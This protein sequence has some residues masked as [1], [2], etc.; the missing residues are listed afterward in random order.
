MLASY[1]AVKHMLP[2][3]KYGIVSEQGYIG[4][5]IINDIWCM[6]VIILL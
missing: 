6:Y 2:C 1:S 3:Q 5:S 4:L